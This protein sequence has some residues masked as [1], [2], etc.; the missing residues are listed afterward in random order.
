M[1]ALGHLYLKNAD[2][3]LTVG[4]C[5]LHTDAP[6]PSDRSS[7][8]TTVQIIQKNVGLRPFIFEKCWPPLDCW[9]LS[10]TYR[11]SSLFATSKSSFLLMCDLLIIYVRKERDFMD[12]LSDNLD[13]RFP[14][15]AP[16][17]PGAPR[18]LQENKI[19]KNW[20]KLTLWRRNY[21]SLILA[22][23]VYKMWII[24]E[25]NKLALWNKLHFEEE[26]T[27]SIEHV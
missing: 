8:F 13:Q 25:P 7:L 15:C 21:F 12:V 11:Y 2:R 22:H 18:P 10:V 20:M 6:I 5:L 9:W 4:D 17:F 19:N 14:T 1:W 24:Q 26:K 16:H 23:P 3:H 27:E